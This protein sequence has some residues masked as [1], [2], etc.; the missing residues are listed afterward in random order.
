MKVRFDEHKQICGELNFC[1]NLQFSSMFFFVCGCDSFIRIEKD[2]FNGILNT[3]LFNLFLFN[4]E[5]ISNTRHR[6]R[7]ENKHQLNTVKAN[8]FIDLLFF[9]SATKNDCFIFSVF[10]VIDEW[11]FGTKMWILN[12]TT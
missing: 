12:Q 6:T 3:F 2:L 5:T 10:N 9:N 7:I 4:Q 8:Y 11:M 1:F